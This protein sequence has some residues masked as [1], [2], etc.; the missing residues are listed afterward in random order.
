MLLRT[1]VARFAFPLLIVGI[2]LAWSGQTKPRPALWHIG[3][4]ACIAAGFVGVR[5]RHGGRGRLASDNL[6]D[7]PTSGPPTRDS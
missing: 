3:A 4:G 6:R 2:A 5:L 7:P 1:L